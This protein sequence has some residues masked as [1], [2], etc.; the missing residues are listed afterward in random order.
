MIWKGRDG[1]FA[2]KVLSCTRSIFCRCDFWRS[3]DL[4]ICRWDWGRTWPSGLHPLPSPSFHSSCYACNYDVQSNVTAV[5]LIW[6]VQGFYSVILP[7]IAKQVEYLHDLK[8][9]CCGI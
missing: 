1:Q 3:K 5:L 4:V 9:D 8:V 6:M 7:N 2:A